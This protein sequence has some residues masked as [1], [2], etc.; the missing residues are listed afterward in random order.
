MRNL[1]SHVRDLFRSR[2]GSITV[3]FVA[4][5]PLLIAALA[6]SYEF[7]RAFWAFDVVARD[8]RAGVRY[9]A[10]MPTLPAPPECPASAKNIIQTGQLAGEKHFPWRDVPE[11][12]IEFACALTPFASGNYNSDGQIISMTATVPVTLSL[13]DWI[14]G[15][16]EWMNL[17]A[18][19]EEGSSPIPI[20]YSLTVSYQAR[21]IG[22]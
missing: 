20:S 9:L 8:V 21:H 22:N 11:E 7:G 5:A 10:R 14:N 2:N 12:D 19:E 3:E 1:V 15:L 13:L 6:F 16:S 18:G 17:R 4:F